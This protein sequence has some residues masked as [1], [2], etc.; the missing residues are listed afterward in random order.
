MRSD[1]F[2]LSPHCFVGARGQNLAVSQR[3]NT[4]LSLL[5]SFG[6]GAD[7]VSETVLPAATFSISKDSTSAFR[8]SA[9]AVT[10]DRVLARLAPR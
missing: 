4:R 5:R 2:S 6:C 10:G 1:A 3:W 9:A 8:G 7:E